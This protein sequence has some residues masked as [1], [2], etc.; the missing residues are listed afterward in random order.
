MLTHEERLQ[1]AIVFN[2]ERAASRT[3]GQIATRNLIKTSEL[4]P[5][6]MAQLVGI[7]P[8]W[9]PDTNYKV[10]DIAAY[11]GALYE[12]VQAH[13]S[14]ADWTPDTVPALFKSHA[15]VGVIPEWTQPTGGHNAYAVGE[16]VTYKG[17]V[18]TSKIPA[19][20]TVPDGDEPYNRYWEPEAA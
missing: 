2:Q 16:Q 13:T 4:T 14:Q 11:H 9:A 1:R 18:W 7:Y 6:E 19:N 20:T 15:P 17:K 5:E 3:A 12:T 10:G 8:A